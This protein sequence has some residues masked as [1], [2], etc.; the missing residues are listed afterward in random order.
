MSD[1]NIATF[2]GVVANPP[3]TDKHG[4]TTFNLLVQTEKVRLEGS[5]YVPD[6]YSKKYVKIRPH[7]FENTPIP[8]QGTFVIA[9]G[10]PH[11]VSQYTKKDG[12]IGFS[13]QL[14]Q[15]KFST[16]PIPA[17]NSV[18]HNPSVGQGY[19]PIGAAPQA[20]VQQPQVVA[21][22]AVAPATSDQVANLE[23]QLAA[24]K[25]AATVQPNLG[26]VA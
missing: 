18:V 15:A 5:Q 14:S 25:N 16:G 10:G 12:T 19:T 6:G 2:S 20:P 22:Q 21:Q 23:A 8:G 9:T 13:E 24:A 17:D 11:S 4:N 7:K 26:A 1:I 3:Q